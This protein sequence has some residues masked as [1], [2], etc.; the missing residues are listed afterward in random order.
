MH[1][2]NHGTSSDFGFADNLLSYEPFP[3]ILEGY[4]I[5][6]SFIDFRV[7]TESCDQHHK[8]ILGH[9]LTSREISCPSTPSK[10]LSDHKSFCVYGF[11]CFG[12]FISFPW[13]G[14][15]ENLFFSQRFLFVCI[16]YCRTRSS[17]LKKL[18]Q[19]TIGEEKQ[20]GYVISF[21]VAI[22][23]N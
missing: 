7:H 17:I 22:P 12:H 14:V 21:S 5:F 9:F 20:F 6:N 23:W 16:C 10:V 15:F 13:P 19:R 11:P 2:L 4:V 8:V 18:R 1:R 3:S